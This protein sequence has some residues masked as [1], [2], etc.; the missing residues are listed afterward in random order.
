MLPHPPYVA[1]RD[2]YERYRER[3]RMPHKPRAF[4]DERHPHLGWWR[5]TT[6]I[7]EVSEAEVLRAR[8][9][10]WG[11]VSDLDAMIG[12]I[13]SALHRNGLAEN[14]LVIYTSD[15]GDMLGEHGLWWK[16]TFYE[17]WAST[18]CG[19]NTFFTKNRPRYLSSC[20]GRA[21][22]RLDR[23]GRRW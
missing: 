3:V 12:Q 23:D 6:S 22:C 21:L 10:Y 19:G 7:E 18:G 8:A 5:R 16:H 15:H 14:T 17:C 11:M 4:A 13:L 20:T 1:R 2:A 9:A